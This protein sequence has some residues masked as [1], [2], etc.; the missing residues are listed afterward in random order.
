MTHYDVVIVGAG[1]AGLMCA[2]EAGKRGRR[3]LLLDHARKA[4]K[5]ILIS[6][7]G[8][9]NFTNYYVEPQAY[10]SANPHFCISALQRYTQ[11]D[12]IALVEKHGIAY[13]EKTLGQLFCDTSAK[14]IVAMLLAECA[15]NEVELRLETSVHEVQPQGSGFH[16]VTSHGEVSCDSLVLASGGLSIPKMGASGFALD[17]A[18]KF[19]IPVQEPRPAL[20]PFT[21][22]T[23]TLA[24]FHDLSGISLAVRIQCNGVEFL[25]NL[26]FTH[27][28]LSG[29]AILQISSYWHPGDALQVDL[30]PGRD[31]LTWLQEMRVEQPRTTIK[32]LLAENWPKRFAQRWCEVHGLED[33]LAQYSDVRLAE[34]AQT[35]QQW[36]LYPSGTEGYRIAEVMA[37]GVDT[38]ALSS[39]T[40][41]SRTVPG[42]Y[43]IGECVDVTGWL[44][45]YNFQWAWSSGWCAGQFV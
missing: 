5:K 40:L 39:K 10:I 15:A 38:R 41:E 33:S 23:R 31:V 17:L 4:G 35:I 18:R 1:A 36:T 21:L 32:N 13:H 14:A 20:V 22:N 44:G 19:S 26:L 42:L 9:C 16:C 45:G 30:L 28:G 34:M 8:R 43:F 29:P 27:R 11:Y 6:G 2:I 25:E 12:F 37:G 7:G 24:R 3:V